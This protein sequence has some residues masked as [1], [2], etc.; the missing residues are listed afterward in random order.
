[1]GSVKN[2]FEGWYFKH[3]IGE[4]VFSFIVSF[5]VDK[6]GKE[7]AYVQFITKEGSFGQSFPMEDCYVNTETFYMK[8]GNNR[9]GRE[10][11]R[12]SMASEQME[13]ACNVKYG[14]F[15][16]VKPDIMGPFQRIPKMECKHTII[17]M[18]H[19]IRG[20]VDINGEA[21]ELSGGRGYIEG[22]RG[23]SFP[24]SYMWSQCNFKYKGD[25]SIMLACGEVPA[26]I[27][28]F[29]GII[30]QILYRGKEYR[31]AT[32]LGAK[33]IQKTDKSIGIKQGK[34]QV[35]IIALENQGHTLK[36]PVDG[37]LKRFVY[38]NPGGRVRYVF[39]K[40]DNKIFD[41]ISRNGSFE[42]YNEEAK[43]KIKDKIK[44]KRKWD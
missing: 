28:H 1:M 38:E 17:S 5:Q 15:T 40:N 31:L 24:K 7:S 44:R 22:D 26:I 3:Q 25:H 21:T 37:A 41:F 34:M 33:I 9:F 42:S 10:G 11:C 39:Y 36:A 4:L 2:H 8:I 12:V 43:L 29:Q 18:T 23:K 35:F 6:Q 14:P 32:Y 13:V 27:G 30:C 20:F 16:E 19:E